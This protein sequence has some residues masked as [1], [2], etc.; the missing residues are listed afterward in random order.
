VGFLGDVQMGHTSQSCR[1]VGVY[2]R[3]NFTIKPYANSDPVE[4]RF[5]VEETL[6]EYGVRVK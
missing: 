6:R 2:V 5:I 1:R 4:A 3:D